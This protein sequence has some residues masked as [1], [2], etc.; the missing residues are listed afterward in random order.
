MSDRDYTFIPREASDWI[1]YTLADGRTVTDAEDGVDGEISLDLSDGSVI[2]TTLAAGPEDDALA[3]VAG[4][5]EHLAELADGPAVNPPDRDRF[6]EL[7]HPPTPEEIGVY[8]LYKA[9]QDGS[10]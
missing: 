4:A 6:L 5:T 8:E 3:S 1:G 7:G 10:L 2:V 9:A